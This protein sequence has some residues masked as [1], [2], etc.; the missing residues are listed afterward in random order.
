MLTIRAE[1]RH[2]LTIFVL[3]IPITEIEEN[4]GLKTSRKNL[5]K[6]SLKRFHFI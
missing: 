2:F 3:I 6:F 5:G 1:V 4:V